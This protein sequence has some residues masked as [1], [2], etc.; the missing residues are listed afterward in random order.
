M[1]DLDV[2][3]KLLVAMADA[4]QVPH[5]RTGTRQPLLYLKYAGGQHIQHH[6]FDQHNSRHVD[7]EML[8][9]LAEKGLI[10]L[11][12]T[13]SG[14]LKLY[15]TEQGEEVAA[16]AK[17]FLEGEPDTPL[18][19]DAA[20]DLSWES[21]GRPTLEVAY[22][23]WAA[24][25]APREGVTTTSIFNELHKTPEQQ[26]ART[27]ALLVEGNYLA[28]ASALSTEFGPTAVSVTE[29]GLQVVAGWP[30]TTAEAAAGSLLAALE[31]AIEETDEP[32]RKSKLERLREVALDVG[33]G[34]LAQVL[35]H[36]ITG[37]L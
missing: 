27:I 21:S 9:R 5:E 3:L 23:L 37:G 18:D 15:L 26:T 7:D 28:R 30:A 12:Y 1:S 17:R 34:T 11:D 25:G 22:R 2:S 10:R 6:A 8:E 33:Q 31:Q 35:K 32:E 29:R 4:F 13:G 14:S 24:R 36:V 19:P 20:V 16:E